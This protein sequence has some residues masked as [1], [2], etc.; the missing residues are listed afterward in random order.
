MARALDVRLE[1]FADPVGRLTAA[2]DGAIAFAYN[3]PYLARPDRAPLSLALPLRPEAFNDVET[4]AFFDNLLPENNQLMQVMEREG[5]A[6]TDIVGL[7]FFL[8][9]DCSGA[10]SCGPTD[11]PPLK[12]PGSLATDYDALP[13]QDFADIVARLADRLPL[14][15]E[16]RDPSPVA[17]VQYKV[18][19]ALLP[20][21]RFA[22]PKPGLRVP[23]THI[24]KVPRRAKTREASLEVA[25]AELCRAVRLD[26]AVPSLLRVGE[27]DAV[28][29]A[30]FDR[31]IEHDNVVRRIHQEDFAQALGLPATLKYERYGREGRRFDV[32][33]IV[34]VLDQTQ[35]PATA[36]HAFLMATF[37]NLF[38]GNT[39]NHAKNHAL[40]YDSGPVPKLAPLYDLLPIRLDPPVTHEL[41]FRIGK[42]ERFD[43]AEKTD[44]SAFFAAFGLSG[45]AQRRFVSQSLL[46]MLAAID[47]ASRG[48]AAQGLKDFDDLIGREAGRFAEV[49]ELKPK[50]RER[51]YFAAQAG[52]WG[53]PS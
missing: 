39:D 4:R 30:R 38:I 29:I 24:V 12:I 25:A 53:M 46:P 49:L 26:V 23:T 51:D 15:N 18:A 10:V 20:D 16:M 3:E 11:G 17:G 44:F 34:R 50:M 5:L 28:L 31:K 1:Q 40:L 48:F 8:G 43:A 45:T 13:D 7:L 27:L 2:D 32:A 9:A 37:F 33:S 22:V 42:A 36:R 35:V 52:G 41:S 6:R 19:L 14:P 47:Q 21:G